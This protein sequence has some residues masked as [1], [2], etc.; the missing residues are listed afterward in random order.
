MAKNDKYNPNYKKLYPGI[1]ISPK[2]L[3][4]LKQSDR[5]MKYI[6]MDLKTERFI[7]SQEKQTAIFLPSRE[8][9][10]DR[11]CEEEYVQFTSDEDLPE[12]ELLRNEKIQ[13]L[14]AAL[15]KLEPDEAALIRALFYSGISE[16]E[17]ARQ[18]KISQKGVNKRKKKVLDKLRSILDPKN[19]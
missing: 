8:D 10:Y 2:I 1:E 13:L 19:K 5:K 6:E 17:Y 3:T 16:R 7:H 15:L 18:L 4:A 11:M 14:R 9:S 12:D